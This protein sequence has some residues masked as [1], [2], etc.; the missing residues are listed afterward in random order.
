MKRFVGANEEKHRQGSKPHQ[1]GNRR[2][3]VWT[4]RREENGAPKDVKNPYSSG[5]TFVDEGER[6][7]DAKIE[8][9]MVRGVVGEDRGP[10][11]KH[12]RREFGDGGAGVERKGV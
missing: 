7:N 12:A 1:K 11:P 3:G 6:E 4:K 5:T 8:R 9:S 10:L 2:V